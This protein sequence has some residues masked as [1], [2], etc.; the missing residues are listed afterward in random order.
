MVSIQMKDIFKELFDN[1]ETI[2]EFIDKYRIS[3][4]LN[5]E[6]NIKLNSFLVKLSNLY[7]SDFIKY[8]ITNDSAEILMNLLIYIF[9]KFKSYIKDDNTSKEIKDYY[10]SRAGASIS[11]AHIYVYTLPNHHRT[12]RPER[13][14]IYNL[15]YLNGSI[16]TERQVG[17]ILQY[18]KDVKDL[19]IFQFDVGYMD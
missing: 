2:N 1:D 9:N 17:D 10:E 5:R 4:G 3:Y 6:R 12:K 19:D 8:V 18:L 11:G 7:D 16:G 14:N 13:K 15:G